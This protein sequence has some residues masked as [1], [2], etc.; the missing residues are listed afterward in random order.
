MMNVL[1]EEEVKQGYRLLFDG[2]SMS[3]WAAT[4]KPEGW[5]VENGLLVCKGE[6]TGYL[7][8]VEQFENF[9]FQLEY[10]AAPKTNSGVFFRWSNLEDPVHTGLEM[11]IWDTYDQEQMV[12]NSSGALYDL[13]APSV[14][15]VRPAEE[16]NQITIKCDRNQ[17]QLT[18]NGIVVVDADIDQWTTAGKN[19]DGSDNKFHFAWKDMPRRGHIGLQ[20][21]GG[22]I[23]FRNIKIV[24]LE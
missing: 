6:T 13:V 5:L 14:N 3:G 21:H 22:Y 17:I 11:Q 2:V 4:S 20:D 12:R 7:Y 1:A 8:T 16:W 19:P 10:K 18:L 15:A 24:E 23:E 9:V